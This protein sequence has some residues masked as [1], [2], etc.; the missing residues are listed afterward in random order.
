MNRRGFLAATA[1]LAS[2]GCVARDPAATPSP[3]TTPSPTD[4][5][6]R[7]GP[8]NHLGE[9]VLWNDHDERHT[10]SLEVRGG[11]E[12]FL[13]VER[14]LD[15]GA[16][17]RLDNPIER[18]GTY[19]VTASLADGGSGSI[20]WDIASCGNYEYVRS[21]VTDSGGVSVEIGTRTVMPPPE[22]E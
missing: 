16:V 4:A 6:A 19:R 17:V 21:H 11:G 3:S 1:A 20:E 8:A 18:Q 9:F 10:L 7:S 22:C 14:R 12:T 13:D 15:P 5:G 2:T